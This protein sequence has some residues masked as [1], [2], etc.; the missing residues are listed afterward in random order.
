MIG[1]LL[2]IIQGLIANAIFAWVTKSYI[3]KNEEKAVKRDKKFIRNSKVEFYA[4][5]FLTLFF[6]V[7]P[8][9][10]YQIANDIIRALTLISLGFTLM[11]FMCIMEIV[12][13]FIK[14][15]KDNGTS[16]NSE[17]LGDKIK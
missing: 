13:I 17:N 5:F 9:S 16:N 15:G 8:T 12:D 1:Y 14:K 10:E 2:G 3:S 6:T 11:G 7:L 4:G